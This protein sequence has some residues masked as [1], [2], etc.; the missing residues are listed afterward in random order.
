M[1]PWDLD[2]NSRYHDGGQVLDVEAQHH[3]ET[4]QLRQRIRQLEQVENK[5][6]FQLSAPI[7]SGVEPVSTCLLRGFS[8]CQRALGFWHWWSLHSNGFT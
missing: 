1:K 2:P 6:R 5:F 7:F 8:G 4:E 3:L